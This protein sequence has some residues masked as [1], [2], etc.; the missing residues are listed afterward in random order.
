MIQ[1][2]LH[3]LVC[4]SLGK[5]R[6]VVLRPSKSEPQTS[7]DDKNLNV[8]LCTWKPVPR[9]L[10]G[11][12]SRL[13]KWFCNFCNPSTHFSSMAPRRCGQIVDQ[14]WTGIL[15]LL[16][17]KDSIKIPDD[18]K[19]RAPCDLSIPKSYSFVGKWYCRVHFGDVSRNVAS[20]CVSNTVEPLF[21]AKSIQI[22]GVMWG[23]SGTQPQNAGR[24][25]KGQRLP[26]EIYHCWRLR[27][28]CFARSKRF[29]AKYSKYAPR[30]I[31]KCACFNNCLAYGRFPKTHCLKNCFAQ[32]CWFASPWP[33]VVT[34]PRHVSL[35]RHRLQTCQDIQDWI[36]M[37]FDAALSVLPPTKMVGSS[38][39]RLTNKYC[40]YDQM[41]H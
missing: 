32:K 24:L 14:A 30:W 27:T 9:C 11:S 18:A 21:P 17:C 23:L 15:E 5:R 26:E 40:V 41:C 31:W 35:T 33:H 2:V 7:L 29:S 10:R 38:T 8:S 39:S 37:R 36:G 4:C 6:M 1:K 22:D 28:W 16:G 13:S 19:Q 3:S 12:V 20:H 34:T 25:N